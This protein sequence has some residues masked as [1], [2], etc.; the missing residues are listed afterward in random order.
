MSPQFVKPRQGGPKT[1][2]VAAVAAKY[3][4][5]FIGNLPIDIIIYFTATAFA[6]RELRYQPIRGTRASEHVN[7]LGET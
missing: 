5:V 1:D 7:A 2:V 4:V 3:I 6:P